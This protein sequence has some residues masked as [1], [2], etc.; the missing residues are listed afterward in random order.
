MTDFHVSKWSHK[1]TISGL[2][3]NWQDLCFV[4][5]YNVGL[6]VDALSHLSRL[7]NL[8][9]TAFRVHDALVNQIH[10]TQSSTSTFTFPTLHNLHLNSPSLTH[11]WRLLRRFRVPVIRDLS[12]GLHARPTTPDLM[13]FFVALQEASSHAS[14]KSLSFRVYYNDNEPMNPSVANSP[15][16]NITFERLRPLMVFVNIQSIALHI[17][18]GVDLNERELLILASSWPQLETFELGED[19]D[20]A[21]SSGITP[22]GFLQLLERCRSLRVFCLKFDTRGYTEIPQ[23]HPWRGLT[24]PKDSSISF[25]KSPI[26]EESIEALGVFFHVAPYPDF[27]MTTDWNNR[28]FRGREHPLELCELY[29]DRWAEVR[30]LARDLSKERANLRHSLETP[31]SWHC[32]VMNMNTIKDQSRSAFKYHVRNCSVDLRLVSLPPDSPS[33]DQN[34]TNCSWLHKQVWARISCMRLR[35]ASLALLVCRHSVNNVH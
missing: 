31:S 18:C 35:V 11:I 6:N 26:E 21:T 15:L 4:H 33:F 3:C 17:P 9:Y 2:I 8:L 25:F 29:C 5:C 22:E 20:W 13:S 28:Y 24:V 10:T 1:E 16:Y 30:G 32:S 14:L 19:Y 7:R 34:F 27:D 23:G 12:V